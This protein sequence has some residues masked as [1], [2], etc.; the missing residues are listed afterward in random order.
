MINF[1]F[2]KVKVEEFQRPTSNFSKMEIFKAKKNIVS[3]L[4]VLKV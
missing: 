4:R 3:K 2:T 1:I